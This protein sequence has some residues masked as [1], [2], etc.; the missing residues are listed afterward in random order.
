[1]PLSLVNGFCRCMRNC[2]AVAE[3]VALADPLRQDVLKQLAEW[4][5]RYVNGHQ[6]ALT[7][8]RFGAL[9]GLAPLG[10][11]FEQPIIQALQTRLCGQYPEHLLPC[12]APLLAALAKSGSECGLR[13]ADSVCV[14]MAALPAESELQEHTLDL[15]EVLLEAP[16]TCV[17]EALVVLWT[18][19]CDCHIRRCFELMS[20]AP[21]TQRSFECL[22]VGLGHPDG[23][24]QQLAVRSLTD[25]PFQGDVSDM[26]PRVLQIAVYQDGPLLERLADLFLVYTTAS[27]LMAAASKL[28]VGITDHILRAMVLQSFEKLSTQP[29]GH[30]YSRASS[31]GV[32]GV[33]EFLGPR[34][35][36]SLLEAGATQKAVL[37]G[38]RQAAEAVA[39]RAARS[40]KPPKEV[41]L[42]ARE[43]TVTAGLTKESL[44]VQIV[45][46]AATRA[47]AAEMARKQAGWH[48]IAAA[49]VEA[50]QDSLLPAEFV[51]R[52]AATA[53]AEQAAK[54]AARRSK[55]GHEASKPASRVKLLQKPGDR[56]VGTASQTVYL[57]GYS[58]GSPSFATWTAGLK[59]LLTK[60]QEE[61]D[62]EFDRLAPSAC[63]WPALN[64]VVK[65]GVTPPEGKSEVSDGLL[66]DV[67]RLSAHA[68][69]F[70]LAA[71]SNRLY[72]LV[73]PGAA[74][75][76]LACCISE[77]RAFV[78][79]SGISDDDV[80]LAE[81]V[82]RPFKPVWWICRDRATSTIM[83]AIRGT[84]SMSDV[85]SDVLA[86]QTLYK[87]HVIHEGV[88]ASARWVY[89]K[90]APVLHRESEGGKIV[91]TGHSLGGAVA[92]LLAW[93][94]REDAGLPARAFVFGVPQ[95]TDEALARKMARFVTGIIH[96]RDIIPMLSQ[97]S[98][99][100]LRHQVAE[101]AQTP[102][103]K[104]LELQAVLANFHL[105]TEP[106]SL[107]DALSQRHFQAP[108]PRRHTS[109][110]T[111]TT[112]YE[113][114]PSDVA[115]LPAIPMHNPGWQLHL[116]RRALGA[117]S[118]EFKP[119]LWRSSMEDFLI[120]VST[121][122]TAS[123]QRVR[124]A[125]TMWQDHWPQERKTELL[126]L[127]H[128]AM[129]QNELRAFP[130]A[131]DWDDDGHS[132][133]V[134][135]WDDLAESGDLTATTKWRW[136]D[137][138]G[139]RRHCFV[140]YF[141][142]D[143][144]QL[145][146]QLGEEN[147]FRDL[148]FQ[149]NSTNVEPAFTVVD[150][151]GDGDLDW[152]LRDDQGLWFLEFS[153]GTLR[154]KSPIRLFDNL[155][156]AIPGVLA[157]SDWA[158]QPFAAVDWD[159]D[160]DMDLFISDPQQSWPLEI[161]YFERANES[162]LVQARSPL[163][164][165]EADSVKSMVVADFDGDGAKDVLFSRSDFYLCEGPMLGFLHGTEDGNFE[166][167]SQ[168]ARAN[169]FSGVEGA[170]SQNCTDFSGAALALVD[171]NQ[172]ELLELLV[173]TSSRLFLFSWHFT[174]QLVERTNG[175]TLF[176]INRRMAHPAV[177]DWDG[178]GIMDLILGSKYGRVEVFPRQ[179]DGRL[180]DGEIV[181]EL[182]DA[183]TAR[184]V[185]LDFNNDG[186][187]DLM[188][189][190]A[191]WNGS[192]LIYFERQLNGSLEERFR[193][194]PN[195]ALCFAAAVADWSG[196][197]HL[198]LLL[199]CSNET[200]S[201]H[202][203]WQFF[204]QLP[205]GSFQHRPAP[206]ADLDDVSAGLSYVYVQA[207]DV[208]SDGTADLLMRDGPAWR[209]F[210]SQPDGQLIEVNASE[211]LH[212]VRELPELGVGETFV[213]ADWDSDGDVDLLTAAGHRDGGDIRHFDNGYCRLDQACTGRGACGH[214]SGKCT[215]FVGHSRSDCSACSGGYFDPLRVNVAFPARELIRECLACPGL[216]G[217]LPCS[218][219]GFCNDDA[220]TR[221]EHS[222]D[223]KSGTRSTVY[224]NGTCSCSAPFS[225]ERC[226]VGLCL[227]GHK[228]AQLGSARVQGA[229]PW[230]LFCEPCEPG[231]FVDKHNLQ[232]YCKSCPGNSYASDPGSA[233][234]LPCQAFWW[235][236]SVTAD[237]TSCHV[238]FM[239]LCAFTIILLLSF[240]FFAILSHL[241]CCSMPVEDVQLKD[242]ILCLSTRGRHWLLRPA[243][244]AFKDT[245]HP[246]LDD[247]PYLV[248]V[249]SDRELIVCD[250]QGV[251]LSL[252]ADASQG[253]CHIHRLD[254]LWRRGVVGVP[255]L[256]CLGL[257][258]ILFA[259]AFFLLGAVAFDAVMA[260]AGLALAALVHRWTHPTDCDLCR[261]RCHFAAR[262]RTHQPQACPKGPERGLALG[263]I[264]ELHDFFSAY[265][266]LHRNMYYLCSNIVKPM[267]ARDQLSY[268]ELAGPCAV[269]FFV[270]HYWGMPFQHFLECLK[271]HAVDRTTSY[272]ICTFANN[273]WKVAEELGK[274]VLCSPFYL[275]LRSTSCQ[276]TLVVLDEEVL[277][278]TRSWCLFE[279][280]QTEMLSR[281]RGG[282][283]GLLL[284][285]STGVMNHGQSSIDLAL[286]IS[287]KLSTLRLQ[288]AQASCPKDKRLIDEAVANHPGGFEAVNSFL[289]GSVQAALYQ[290]E[291]RFREDFARLHQDL[292]HTAALAED[293]GQATQANPTLLTSHGMQG[294]D[295]ET[296][297]VFY[298][299]DRELKV[300]VVKVPPCTEIV[301]YA[302]RSAF[303]DRLAGEGSTADKVFHFGGRSPAIY[304]M[305][306]LE[307]YG[308]QDERAYLYA[309][310]A[311]AE[312]LAADER[313]ISSL[314][315]PQAA[316]VQAGGA[317]SGCDL[318]QALCRVESYFE[319][320]ESLRRDMAKLHEPPAEC[321]ESLAAL[322]GL[323]GPH[324]S[325]EQLENQLQRFSND[326]RK[327]A[328]G[329]FRSACSVELPFDF[330]PRPLPGPRC[331]RTATRQKAAGEVMGS[332]WHELDSP[333][334]PAAT[335]L[336]VVDCRALLA[337]SRE[338]HLR[339]ARDDDLWIRAFESVFGEVHQP[340]ALGADTEACSQS[341]YT[342]GDLK[343]KS[344][345]SQPF[346]KFKHRWRQELAK[347]CPNCGSANAIVPIVYG[348]PSEPL[349][350][351]YRRGSLVLTE[352]CGF[353][354]PCWACR[355]CHYEFERYPYS[356]S[357][358]AAEKARK[359]PFLRVCLAADEAIDENDGVTTA[360]HAAS[361][362]LAISIFACEATLRAATRAVERQQ[363]PEEVARL[364]LA[365]LTGSGL[366][367]GQKRRYASMALVDTFG[368]IALDGGGSTAPMDLVKELLRA[369]RTLGA[370]EQEAASSHLV[371]FEDNAEAS[372]PFRAMSASSFISHTTEADGAIHII[373][374]NRPEAQ[375]AL[376]M[377][378]LND[379]AS[380]F[381]S[382]RS[383]SK[384][385]AVILTG[386]GQ[387][388]FSAGID[389]MKADGIFTGYFPTPKEQDPR[390]QIETFPWPVI[391]A[392]NGFAITGGFELALACDILIASENASF[393][394]THAKFG[395]APAWGLSQKLTRVMGP[396]R[397]K[398]LHFTGRFLKA[399]EAVSWG[400]VNSVVP[401]DKLMPHCL[402]L[403]TEMTKMNPNMLQMLKRTIDDGYGM[404]FKDGC[405]N[406]QEVAFKYYKAMGKELFDRMKKFIMSRSKEGQSKL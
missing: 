338:I 367:E 185:V 128:G 113:D 179:E 238:S 299:S 144:W 63:E 125:W 210:L 139:E 259:T 404:S 359:Y 137:P 282:F 208:N 78:R 32:G 44:M 168:N 211:S 348:F 142:Q 67:A 277:P 385:R 364:S 309:C 394:D 372:E 155:G 397:A 392:V 74:C 61:E 183:S 384:V 60:A 358:P 335:F 327:A 376:T 176:H 81:T 330:E 281:E 264:Q 388:A 173:A 275:A 345:Q 307:V 255:F 24:I 93:L 184:P 169:P 132:D 274:D 308:F 390:V 247:N 77:R 217:D 36:P 50:A 152:I 405:A 226:E 145:S 223:S 403:A 163:A 366:K 321:K 105:P 252:S 343:A 249:Q 146:E 291:A 52:M 27:A 136:D 35:F 198:D 400:L 75:L 395:I 71:Y 257:L 37:M 377:D 360:A 175:Y 353:L 90:V 232:F 361:A 68:A 72:G 350:A 266:G 193:L 214:S 12:A 91:I 287:K 158:M 6:L 383:D 121:P 112:V 398:E 365:T 34:A 118:R 62:A 129:N 21:L 224:G 161:L 337:V 332:A 140:R 305:A 246:L 103:E 260:L 46:S 17:S 331:S 9:G 336:E 262:L 41:A 197:G 1:M 148:R 82:A 18:K 101:A 141:R 120:T 312:R 199:P 283:Q 194:K 273:Q 276:G 7:E 325:Q 96:A 399:Q 123:M 317:R 138:P 396:S 380:V 110:S 315:L 149:M 340:D 221:F 64:N 167:W 386:S 99:E 289:I 28:V 241:A 369:L 391:C 79:M 242:G 263:K 26:L 156:Q 344:V 292:E 150:W 272:W 59:A 284:G 318:R 45:G 117:R 202:L 244:V 40:G 126:H 11:E 43:A 267:T 402:A 190:H 220:F 290:T 328:N 151:D 30:A 172:N 147:P 269:A 256:L 159:E 19:C 38:A 160:G 239:N 109:T 219:R 165:F 13:L 354:G 253:T 206:L 66:L 33:L 180:G 70:A 215:C 248:E 73:A 56:R 115:E 334:F 301:Q 341:G 171:G 250:S 218:G 8:R 5:P 204:Q 88:L 157:A 339:V 375:N 294:K 212:L 227:P 381:L 94:L 231:S 346:E 16:A 298:S 352:V 229:G 98:V 389:L 279:L 164:G 153:A 127:G 130:Q 89:S 293:A 243:R 189:P 29:L 182:K 329:Y 304:F 228:Y 133:I 166:D 333:I 393:A 213:L 107:Q 104:M 92:A 58:H 245:G 196:D 20:K 406:E 201:A 116:R 86:T 356:S 10:N 23:H 114:A 181:L 320:P 235:R 134:L 306:W 106:A 174:K 100:D 102:E 207:I 351:H 278:L 258:G 192:E 322:R 222:L 209:L 311:L 379:I 288:E 387:K 271:G 323:V 342:S 297:K 371:H 42:A 236:M 124:P 355:R 85:L 254:S 285:T 122:T 225:G 303:L 131:V 230:L 14:A 55:S 370:H 49:V 347:I 39:D 186:L 25:R 2:V 216:P 65:L 3:L 76:T 69:R 135:Q 195:W 314:G 362:P 265:I 237:K 357:A 47:V 95:V 316:R 203:V 349:T 80:L 373:T 374:L 295:E 53:A 108:S 326:P 233:R 280:F 31:G 87:E 143:E 205:N 286:K 154:S 119:I 234:C 240:L 187:N 363:A 57:C 162:A 178:D 51:P 302:A 22:S 401:A 15:C 300:K 310:E 83:V 268:A 48:E 177:A 170:G 200:F 4:D 368:K 324:A 188:V 378:M 111:S 84:F 191:T 54:A 382:L 270:S 296:V 251:A 261:D 319:P 313:S 97:K